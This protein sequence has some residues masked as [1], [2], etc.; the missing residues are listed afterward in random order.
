M[1]RHTSDKFYA[2]LKFFV[3]PAAA[4]TS[5]NIIV[6]SDAAGEIAN[7]V[8]ELGWHKEASLECRWPHNTAHERSQGIIK[9]V[10]RAAMLQSG[11]TEHAWDVAVE[12]SALALSIVKPAPILDWE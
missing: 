2:A 11:L 1:K 10:T 8:D 6:K 9:S 3:G 7:A 4:R 5:P 12:Y